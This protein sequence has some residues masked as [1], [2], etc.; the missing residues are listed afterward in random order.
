MTTSKYYN[1]VCSSGTLSLVTPAVL[2]SSSSFYFVWH[3]SA[4]NTI[5]QQVLTH[6]EYGMSIRATRKCSCHDQKNHR[7]YSHRSG[8]FK[9]GRLAVKMWGV[10]P[11][12]RVGIPGVEKQREVYLT[13][14]H[15]IM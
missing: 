10:S 4:H 15:L 8:Y 2:I 11:T 5:L 14:Q 1:V 7:E 6:L 13:W 12:G 9:T 3:A